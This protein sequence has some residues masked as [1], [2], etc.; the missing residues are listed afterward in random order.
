VDKTSSILDFN[1]HNMD[2]LLPYAFCCRSSSMPPCGEYERLRPSI[3]RMAQAYEAPVP[4][5]DFTSSPICT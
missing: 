3:L 2:D 1:K 4:G 5:K